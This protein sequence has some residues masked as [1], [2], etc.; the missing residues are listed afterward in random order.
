MEYLVPLLGKESLPTVKCQARWRWG[1]DRQNRLGR[2]VPIV[3]HIMFQHYPMLLS[4]VIS[5]LCLMLNPTIWTFYSASEE[6]TSHFFIIYIVNFFSC[7]HYSWTLYKIYNDGSCFSFL[8]NRREKDNSFIELHSVLFLTTVISKKPL[9]SRI[10]IILLLYIVFSSKLSNI[11]KMDV[12]ILLE[13]WYLTI[14][15]EIKYSSWSFA[16]ICGFL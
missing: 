13:T 6:E 2:D 4:G 1:H 7:F 5:V 14:I 9:K 8:E 15:S 10:F 11:L 3:L 16:K 12:I